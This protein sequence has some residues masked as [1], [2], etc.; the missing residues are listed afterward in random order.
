MV[1]VACFPYA[2]SAYWACVDIDDMPFLQS[3]LTKMHKRNSFR[4]G[5]TIP[6]A[7]PAFFG[8]PWATQQEIA[9]ELGANS[10]QFKIPSGERDV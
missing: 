9:E 7:R 4:I 2:A 3:Y 1:D 5:L 10:A 8:P 6:F